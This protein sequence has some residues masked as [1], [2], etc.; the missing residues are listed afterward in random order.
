MGQVAHDLNNQLATILG[1]SEIAMMV[2]DPAR[3]RSAVEE[4]HKAGQKARVLVAD[5]QKL[6]GWFREQQA[7]P[8]PLSDVI[9]LLRR[10]CERRFAR[11][12]VVF[13][14]AHAPARVLSDPVRVFLL[15]W[16][17]L[18][19]ALERGGG[20]ISSTWTL[21]GREEAPGRAWTLEL[22]HPGAVW[23]PPAQPGDER[24]VAQMRSIAETLGATLEFGSENM[25][26]RFG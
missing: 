26:L 4:S 23:G 3:W 6:H 24:R 5:F 11:S 22:A 1:K 12:A 2:D 18:T 9:G 13:E 25:A 19:E 10:V 20:D 15:L 7:S 17:A 8:A 21:A 14:P 16:L